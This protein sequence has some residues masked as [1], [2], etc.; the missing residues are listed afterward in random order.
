ML[1]VKLTAVFLSALSAPVLWSAPVPCMPDT[2]DHYIALPSGCITGSLQ[3]SSFTFA[4]ISG[5]PIS[6]S[7]I[8][9][10]PIQEGLNFSAS[11]LLMGQGSTE[12]EI[13]DVEFDDPR[14][15]MDD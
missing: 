14:D 7:Q 1:L 2:L 15:G 5:L 6:P 12:W 10:T 11:I 9:V 13:G 8:T 4:N 3:F